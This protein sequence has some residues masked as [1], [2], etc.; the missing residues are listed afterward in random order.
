MIPCFVLQ[1][2]ITGLDS[3][4]PWCCSN[5]PVVC[6]RWNGIWPLPAEQEATS[7]DHIIE[8]HYRAVLLQ[9]SWSVIDAIW[10]RL[11]VFLH[12]LVH[13]WCSRNF[14]SNIEIMTVLRVNT[15]KKVSYQTQDLNTLE[16]DLSAVVSLGDSISFQIYVSTRIFH[17]WN[18]VGWRHTRRHAYALVL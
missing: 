6:H 9:E 2:L 4:W 3:M 1:N 11:Q 13:I 18:R 17:I 14:L 10:P 16:V 15:Y 12:E 5:S 7:A 8:F